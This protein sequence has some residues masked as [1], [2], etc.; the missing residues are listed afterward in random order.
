MSSLS[1][2]RFAVSFLHCRWWLATSSTCIYR[3]MLDFVLDTDRLAADLTA[4]RLAIRCAVKKGLL[5]DDY[6]H[7]LS[8][9]LLLSLCIFYSSSFSSASQV[10]DISRG[11]PGPAIQQETAALSAEY[12]RFQMVI[13]TLFWTGLWAVKATFLVFYRVLFDISPAF[14][15]AWWTVTIL[16]LLLFVRL[17]ISALISTRGGNKVSSVR[18]LTPGLLQF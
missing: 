16:V 10:V 18:K 17:A 11:A 1:L 3:Y 6:T 9:V 8:L 15:R 12:A 14:V 5:W 4:G 7:L 13:T 2:G